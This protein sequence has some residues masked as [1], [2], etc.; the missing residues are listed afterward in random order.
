MICDA[1]TYYVY[2][3]FLY[4]GKTDPVGEGLGDYVVVKLMNP[5]FDRG[6]YVT[7]DNFLTNL[8]TAKK[9]KKQNNNYGWHYAPK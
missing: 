8:S 3:A 6:L 9:L 7:K 5:D 2:Q 1:D 4:T